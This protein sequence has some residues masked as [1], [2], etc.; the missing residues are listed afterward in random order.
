MDILEKKIDKITKVKPRYLYT[1]E[2]PFQKS[3]I[4]LEIAI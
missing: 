1:Y 3:W 2:P 4:R